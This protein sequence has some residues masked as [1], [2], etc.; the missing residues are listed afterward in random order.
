[1]GFTQEN[2]LIAIETP[3]GKDQLLLAHFSGSEGISR[4]FEFRLE[5]LSEN[6]AIDFRKIIGQPVTIR[7]RLFDG[8]VR[9]FHGIVS[10]FTQKSGL[11]EKGAAIPEFSSYAATVVPS[12]W[13]LTRTTDARIFQHKSV[14]DIIA[15]VFTDQQFTDYEMKLSGSYAAREYCVQYH[16]TDFNFISRLME[17]EGIFY[18]FKHEE[19]KHTMII[20]DSADENKPCPNQ[21][22]AEYQVDI[23]GLE[24]ED[25]ITDLVMVQEIRPAM[26]TVNDYNFKVPNTDLKTAVSTQQPLG[27]GEREIYDYPADHTTLD[28]GDRL[29]KLR[30]QA[31]E[32]QITTISGSSRCRA[33]TSGTTFAL[34]N[35]YRADMNEKSYLLTT[36]DHEASEPVKAG[37]G[38]TPAA[39]SN[40]FTCIPYDVPFRPARQTPK[41]VVEGTQPAVV[42]GP[43]GEE[44]YTD[45]FGRVM[46]Q[47]IWDREGEKNEYSSCWIR[48]S[49]QWAGPGWGTL[50]LPRIGHEV[51]VDFVEGNPD[52][53]II[54]GSVYN[55]NNK[56]PYDLPAEKTK[57]TIKSN[58]SKGGGGANE[59]RFEDKKEAEEIYLHGQKDWNIAIEN[60]KG[61]TIGHDE[62]LAVNNNRTKTVGVDQSESI[63]ANKSI[64]VGTNHSETI[65]ANMDQTVGVNKSEKVGTNKTETV[66][67]AKAETIGAAKAL[68]IGAAYQVSVGGAMN[69]TVGAAKAEEIG[70]L[71]SVNVGANSSENIAGNKSVDAG[72][73]ISE[74]AGKKMS[75]SAGDDFS[76][77]GKKKGVIDIS[78]QLTIKVGKA[79]IT[80]KKNGD[81]SLQGAKINIKGSGNITIKGSKILEN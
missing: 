54:I 76:L 50:F 55:G 43:S 72:K 46:V 60:D 32:A 47:F 21:K 2:K 45:A 53:P 61:Q 38:Q 29:A 74:S 70:G 16:E 9:Y 33:F 69:E 48:V 44:I 41:P 18:Y 57:T 80:L 77:S 65:G 58:S 59:F 17:Q 63:G 8:D 51:I 31:E 14:P 13:L 56:P 67:A 5:L 28:E 30:I 64:D 40:H 73:D 68:S 3:L 79:T 11:P 10:R 35:Y 42:V 52:K 78:D 34:K 19:K 22:E 12:L 62:T 27:P 37:D 49:Q 20:A 71:K 15:Q 25:K 1:M 39:Y 23:S 66:G 26:V 6:H 81:I 75:L 24:S 7:V 4:L 36:I